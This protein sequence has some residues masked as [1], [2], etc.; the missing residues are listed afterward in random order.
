[1]GVDIS[2]L[3]RE[4]RRKLPT[5]DNVYK[6]MDAMEAVLTSTRHDAHGADSL[7]YNDNA[8]D[9]RLPYHKNHTDM[10]VKELK[11]QL[12][13]NFDVVLSVGCVHVEF[14]PKGE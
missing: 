2:R 5:I 12:G 14:D 11:K 4:I 1:M 13:V 9:V 7:H 3:K 6:K 10:V 8:V